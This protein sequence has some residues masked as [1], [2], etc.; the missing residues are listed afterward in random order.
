[1]G[2]TA[3][4]GKADLVGDVEKTLEGKGCVGSV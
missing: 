2:V 1:M 4:V 3:A